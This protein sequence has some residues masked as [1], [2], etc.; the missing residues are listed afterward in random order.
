MQSDRGSAYTNKIFQKTNEIMNRQQRLTTAYH[1]QANAFPE[2]MMRCF[3]EK[4]S[5]YVNSSQTD[6]S[7]YV[8]FLAFAYNTSVHSTTRFEP[9]YLMYG[10]KPN[11][12][13]DTVL[14]PNDHIPDKTLREQVLGLRSKWLKAIDFAEILSDK[15]HQGNA[16][17]YDEKN[18]HQ[19]FFG[20]GFG[21][22]QKRSKNNG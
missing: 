16:D 3:G 6:W 8:Q 15:D 20:W 17:A 12:P 1:P 13:V 7:S 9:F 2:R 10:R 5:L 4:L 11:L 14:K 18:F 21:F 19:K 22:C